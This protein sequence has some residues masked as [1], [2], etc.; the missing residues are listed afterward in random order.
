MKRL[1]FLS[2]TGNF[3][4]TIPEGQILSISMVPGS[5]AGSWIQ[6]NESGPIFVPPGI[7]YLA[8]AAD[9]GLEPGESKCDRY[10]GDEGITIVFGQGVDG[11][12]IDPLTGDPIL[13][14]AP[15]SWEVIYN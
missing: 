3:Q 11:P 1:R 15:I 8:R 6:I 7:V 9:L 12:P 2:G 5:D 4:Q 13:L 14:D 10:P